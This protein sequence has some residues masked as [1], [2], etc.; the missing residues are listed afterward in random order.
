MRQ[1]RVIP[2]SVKRIRSKPYV[3]Q[4]SFAHFDAVGIRVGVELSPDLQASLRAGGR[5]QLYDDRMTDQRLASPILTDEGKQPA[6]DLVPLAGPRR[7]MTDRNRNLE[8][9]GQILNLGLPQT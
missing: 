8:L 9:I 4:L 5:N 7:E 3:L 6:L 1:D 2:I